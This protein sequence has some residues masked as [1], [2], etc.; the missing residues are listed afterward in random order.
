M[1]RVTIQRDIDAATLAAIS[2]PGGFYPIMAYFID[3]PDA[4]VYAH[5]NHGTMSWDGQSWTGV[6]S[7]AQI[8]LPGGQVGMAA[9]DGSFVLT[10]I[11]D[12]L[13]DILERDAREREVSFYFG[14][15]TA[16]DGAVPVGDLWRVFT[17]VID[18]FDDAIEKTDLGRT[19]TLTVSIVTGPSQRSTSYVTHT[20]ESQQAEYPTDTAG[21]L[22]INADTEA[23]KLRWPA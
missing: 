13:D 22:T 2:D 5:S 16:R 9:Q 3:W 14:A 21:R 19:R 1:A 15:V 18:G 12:V 10:G 11:G 7:A 8:S 17:G 23:A 6:G 20:F 4:P